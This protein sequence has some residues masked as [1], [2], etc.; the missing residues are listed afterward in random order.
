MI[1]IKKIAKNNINIV[2]NNINEIKNRPLKKHDLESFI[3]RKKLFNPDNTPVTQNQLINYIHTINLRTKT[4]NDVILIL[5][6]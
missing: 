5:D 3:I 2:K 4:I 6:I 1:N